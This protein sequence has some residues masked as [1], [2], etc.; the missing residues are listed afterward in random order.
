EDMYRMDE[1]NCPRGKLGKDRVA[2]GAGKRTQH[3]QGGANRETVMALVTICADGSTLR[4]TVIFKGQNLWSEWTENNGWTDSEI[5][6]EWIKT[7]FDPQTREKA[8][9]RRRVL[10]MDG[11]SSH[12]TEPVI[13]FALTYDIIVMGY[14]PHCTHALQGLDVVCFAK[15]KTEL[16]DAVAE[17]EGL[18][19]N[20][21]AKGDFTGVFGAAFVKAF[22]EDSVLAAFRA[23]GIHPYDPSVI[24]PEKLKPAEALSVK[25]SFALT[26]TSPVK[27]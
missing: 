15:M 10:L 12:F 23:T 6:I 8:Q 3:Q 1:T 5:A 27:A 20:P 11:H 2:G 13:Q 26:Q 21:V 9:S 16:K 14:P 7:Q 18:H 4:P 17:F 19:G 24:K 22:T 25:S